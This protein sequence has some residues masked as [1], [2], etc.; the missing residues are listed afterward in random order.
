MTIWATVT[1]RL[2]VTIWVIEGFHI[3]GKD[4]IKIL[5]KGEISMNVD[6]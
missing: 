4:Y 6:F 5:Y 1:I 3:E 2:I